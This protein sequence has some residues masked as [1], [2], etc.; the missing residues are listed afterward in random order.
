VL[1]LL[2]LTIARD[3]VRFRPIMPLGVLSKASFFATIL[4]LWLGGRS[5]GPSMVFATIDLALG[6]A[7]AFAWLRTR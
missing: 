1:Q 3:P 4:L 7:F 6:I 5:A 2:Y